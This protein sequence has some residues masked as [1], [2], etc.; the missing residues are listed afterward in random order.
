LRKA[1]T[2]AENALWRCLKAKRF[3][4]LKFRRQHPCGPY[5]VDFYCP[6]KRLAVELDGGQHFEPTA[7]AY[8][9]R[10][11]A[12][13]RTR[14]ITVIRFPTDLVFRDLRAVLEEIARALGLLDDPSP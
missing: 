6:R 12:Y 2:D 5:I 3:A 9:A 11:T 7:I 13:L 8:D 10:R 1:S 4:A 14:R